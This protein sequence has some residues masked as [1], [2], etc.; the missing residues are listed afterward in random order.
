M[1]ANER[2]D[3]RHR[4]NVNN[5]ADVVFVGRCIGSYSTQNRER[6]KPRW[7]ELRLWETES[8]NWIAESVGMTS[9]P[10]EVPLT[11]V[12]VIEAEAPPLS[13]MRPAKQRAESEAERRI[14]VM[15]AFGWTS[16]AKA[17]ARELGWDVVRNVP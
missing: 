14:S 12:T 17:F 10:R 15:Q 13:D 9:N 1:K 6:T 3:K 7:T 8:G 4:I 11:D 5:G 2:E 16:A